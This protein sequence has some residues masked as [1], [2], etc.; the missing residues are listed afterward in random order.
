VPAQG[1][2]T[3][4]QQTGQNIMFTGAVAGILGNDATGCVDTMTDVTGTCSQFDLE[5]GTKTATTNCSPSSS[6]PDPTC[7]DV[8]IG[9]PSGVDDL[10]LFVY[11]CPDST[12]AP[13]MGIAGCTQVAS[14]ALMQGDITDT[15]AEGVR[16]AAVETVSN[17]QFY[18]VMVVPNFSLLG[19]N[20]NGCA[21]YAQTCGAIPQEAPTSQPTSMFFSGCTGEAT[22]PFGADRKMTG[23]AEMPAPDGTDKAHA[24]LDVKR[25]EGKLKGKVHYKEDPDG[26]FQFKSTAIGCAA[27][28]DGSSTNPTTG[29]VDVRGTGIVKQ[30]GLSQQVCFESHVSDNGEPGKGMDKF[31][32]TFYTQT[33]D[34]CSLSPIA[35]HGQSPPGTIITG[36]NFDYHF[37]A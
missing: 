31:D 4:P 32:I 22:T 34:Q 30:A 29:K 28:T 6:T 17:A 19:S 3:A 11:L 27:F 15:P 13:A 25:D 16:F 36:G 37:N 9:W 2:I 26:S 5:V 1:T 23:G 14:S 18:R 10:D 35:G 7:V 8:T 12:T 24:S 33:G 20:Y 21:G